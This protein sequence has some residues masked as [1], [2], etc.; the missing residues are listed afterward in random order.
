M[1][2]DILKMTDAQ[3]EAQAERYALLVRAGLEAVDTPAEN[4]RRKFFAIDLYRKYQSLV[5]AGFTT[6]QA[7][8]L[9]KDSK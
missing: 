8:I 4:D 9:V 6:E 2:H 1:T 5:A 7:L 3:R